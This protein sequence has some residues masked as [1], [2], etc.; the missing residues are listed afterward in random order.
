MYEL[1]YKGIKENSKICEEEAPY[2]KR[3]LSDPS[4]PRSYYVPIVSQ[5]K[6]ANLSLCRKDT[7][8]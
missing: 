3:I 5:A 6:S 8:C 4:Y 2:I 1:K 7:C